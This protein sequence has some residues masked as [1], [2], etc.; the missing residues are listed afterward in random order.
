MV[1]PQPTYPTQQ[2]GQQPTYGQPGYGQQP[3]YPQQP[4]AQQPYGYGYGYG[5]QGTSGGTNGLATAALICGLGGLVIG[6]TAPVAI[7]LG[8][9]ALVQIKHRNQEGKGMA[10]AGLAIGAVLTLAYIAFFTFII[11]L[12]TTSHTDYGAPTP[13]TVQHDPTPHA[14]AQAAPR[15][16]HTR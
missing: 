14:A 9:A 5:Y 2:Y 4:Y 8:I 7:G 6:I 11:V 3:G 13:T 10:I 1:R 16:L 15:A 12:G